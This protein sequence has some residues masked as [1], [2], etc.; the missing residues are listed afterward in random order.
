[1]KA[2]EM[3]LRV[4]EEGKLELP[5]ELLRRLQPD[6]IVRV[7]VLISEPAD[8]EEQASWSRLTAEQFLTGYSEADA[9][10]DHI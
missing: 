6:Q 9:V 1:M 5:E 3:P 2:Y 7:I 10:Y 4:S 8:A